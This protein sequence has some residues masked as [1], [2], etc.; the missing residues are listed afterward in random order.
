MTREPGAWTRRVFWIVDDG[1][2]HR[3]HASV[4][5]MA[6]AWPTATL[7]HL[8]LRVLAEPGRDLLF[9]RAAQGVETN[10]FLD[11]AEVVARL[12]AFEDH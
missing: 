12:E 10:D 11:L 2:S 1:S 3:G 4:D 8:P 7:I 9:D 6:E 5:R